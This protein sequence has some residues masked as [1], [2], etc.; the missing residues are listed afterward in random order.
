MSPVPSVVFYISG[1]GFGHASRQIE[2]LHAFA[3]RRPNLRLALR[4]SVDPRLLER[5]I[6]VPYELRPGP[7]DSGIVQRSSI[8]H[9]DAATADRTIAFYEPWERRVADETTRLRDLDVA[10][11]VGD[12]P[13]LAFEVASR[14][15]VP[16]VAIGNF[17]WDWI[18]AD[19]PGLSERAPWL[20][21]RLRDAYVKAGL[22]L[23]LPFSGGFEIFP[24]RQRLPLV[25]RRPVLD[26]NTTR[27]AFDLPLDRRV[28]LLSFGG[29]GLPDL[30]LR[31][32][33][34]LD[35][36]I[37]VTTDRVTPDRGA[38]RSGVV[39]IDEGVFSSGTARYEDLVAAVDVVVTKPG[40]GIL[41]ECIAGG[42]P[43]LYTSRGHFREY[44]VLVEAMPRYTRSRFISHKDLFTGRWREALD[45]LLD[46][47]APPE[48][49]AADGADAA[50]DALATFASR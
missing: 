19:E 47:P 27:R 11:I 30:D 15:G 17:T 42:T 37:V 34:C 48:T 26:R 4:T 43:M 16:S 8:E 3:A 40:Y 13:P 20:L 41:A 24:S 28:A 23:E 46:Q 7:C 5:T 25:A 18:Y 22:A 33:D 35:D 44:A 45:A 12:I 9:D 29:Y 50:A 32:L 2:I 21:P 49:L 14:L 10:L 6:R 38:T 1:H 31:A 39:T 36:W